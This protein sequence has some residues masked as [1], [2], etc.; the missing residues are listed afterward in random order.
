MNYGYLHVSS[1]QWDRVVKMCDDF[2]AK[3]DSALSPITAEQKH[4]VVRMGDGFVA[5]VGKAIEIA[6]DNPGML[7]GNFDLEELKRDELARQRMRSLGMKLTKGLEK[8]QNAEVAHGSDAMAGSLDV[9]A[10]AK[11]A[12]DSEGGEELKKMLGKRFERST[13]KEKAAP[14]P[15]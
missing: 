12:G 9:Y 3:L 4:R 14:A 6:D 1:E 5:F 7:R 8:V 13:P 2:L 11:A 15:V 10:F